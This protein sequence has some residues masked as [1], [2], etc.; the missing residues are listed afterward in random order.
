M[1]SKIVLYKGKRGAGKTLS[2][3]KDGLQYFKEGY[4][5]LR[6]F[7]AKFGEYISEDEILNL[8]KTHL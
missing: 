3:V 6:N 8:D 5:V 7:E 2:M 1:T 4:K